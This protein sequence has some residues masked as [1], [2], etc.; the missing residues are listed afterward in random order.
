MPPT[1]KH[2]NKQI[3]ES[4]SNTPIYAKVTLSF[5]GIKY[6][7]MSRCTGAVFSTHCCWQCSW[8]YYIQLY[9]CICS[10]FW[11][12]RRKCKPLAMGLPKYVMLILACYIGFQLIDRFDPGLILIC[13]C[14]IWNRLLSP[15]RTGK[16]GHFLLCI[17]SQ[18][19]IA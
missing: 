13:N 11:S 1:N 16:N 5:L 4:R 9:V 18:G 8:V 3:N 19:A 12:R 2:P 14:C 17:C 15:E 6:A 10:G 7:H